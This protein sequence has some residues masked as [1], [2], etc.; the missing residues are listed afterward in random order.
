MTT[1]TIV[2]RKDKQFYIVNADKKSE[3]DDANIY[4]NLSNDCSAAKIKN[5]EIKIL[6][7]NEIKNAE[8]IG[9]ISYIPHQIRVYGTEHNKSVNI[10]G[11]NGTDIDMVIPCPENTNKSKI[12]INNTIF[13]FNFE[14]NIS[15]E[16]IERG[17]SA[18]IISTPNNGY[19]MGFKNPI[20]TIE[21]RE[22]KFIKEHKY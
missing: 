19:I 20:S 15:Y 13:S 10:E 6:K 8:L 16:V 14:S 9:C 2:Y 11:V 12:A 1:A 4:H 3:Q 21:L 17:N 22:E 5:N 18:I 7:N